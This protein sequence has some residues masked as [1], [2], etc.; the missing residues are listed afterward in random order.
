MKD[1]N[2]KKQ[3]IWRYGFSLA[4]ITSGLLFNYFNIGKEFLGFA[5]VGIWLIYVGFIMIAVITMQL[6]TKK[7]RKVD[8]RSEFI[9]AKA[10]RITFMGII[11]FAFMVMIIDGIKEIGVSYSYFI[12]YLLVGIVLLYLIS[13][14][15]LEKKY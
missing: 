9:A 12:S 2:S 1:E 13:Y 10:S 4:V 6:L 14:K 7:K 5:S 3:I 8:E 15:I 11:I